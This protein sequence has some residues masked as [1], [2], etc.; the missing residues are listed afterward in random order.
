MSQ[1][2]DYKY[3]LFWPHKYDFHKLWGELEST[4][5]S[6]WIGQGPKVDKFEEEYCKSFDASHA[7]AVNSGTSA[8]HL[9]Y[10]ISN[11]KE[12]DNVISPVFTCTATNHALLRTGA[13]IYFNDI[14]PKTMSSSAEHAAYLCKENNIS[15]IVAVHIAGTPCDI[16]GF[17]ELSFKYRIPVVFDACQALGAVYN[18]RSIDHPDNCGDF[19]CHSFQAIK[20]ISTGDGGMLVA[21]GANY[22]AYERGRRL[23]WFDIDRDR[24]QKEGWQAWTSRGVTS[25]QYEIGYKYQMTDITASIGLVGL[26]QIESILRHRRA[27]GEEYIRLLAG[28]SEITLLDYT[29]SSFGMFGVLVEGRNSFCDTMLSKGVEVNVVQLRND[30][31]EFEVFKN[32][33]SQRLPVMDEYESKYVYLPLNA[34]ITVRDVGEI[35][36]IIKE[37]W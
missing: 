32:C 10:V 26:S 22:S 28:V 33:K 29:G 8:L 34:R 23:R 35:C 37:G 5:S 25:D 12:G 21:P 31:K 1:A 7:L 36:K 30:R 3:P 11:I 9:A 6:R 15:A 13:N 2:L 17:T 20:H 27:L 24:K 18:G 16:R 14:D 4:F 19:T